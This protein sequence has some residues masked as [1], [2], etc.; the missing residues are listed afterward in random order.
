MALRKIRIELHKVYQEWH[1]T[2]PAVSNIQG[3]A[4]RDF[5]PS[6]GMFLVGAKKATVSFVISVRLSVRKEH[7]VSHWIKFLLNL[8]FLYFSKICRENSSFFTVCQE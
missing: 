4:H 8:V 1:V 7:L 2:K 3:W 5:A 6:P